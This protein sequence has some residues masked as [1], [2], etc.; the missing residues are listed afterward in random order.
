MIKDHMSGT[1]GGCLHKLEA[2]ESPL[3]WGPWR[4]RGAGL[5]RDRNQGT[6]FKVPAGP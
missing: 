2:R 1:D 4:C 3:H 6:G 5:L